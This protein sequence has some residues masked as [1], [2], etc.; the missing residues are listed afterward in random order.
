MEDDY[1]WLAGW[2]VTKLHAVKKEEL[3]TA[4]EHDWLKSVCGAFVRK[5]PQAELRE[6]QN[7][8]LEK[9]VLRCKH[10][11]RKIKKEMIG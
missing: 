8:K 7:K 11:E 4:D 3:G 1:V 6:W 10:C 9:G 5:T 2:Y